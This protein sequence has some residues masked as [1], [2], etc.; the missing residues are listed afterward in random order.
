MQLLC[1]Y[2]GKGYSATEL[3]NAMPD[4]VSGFPIVHAGFTLVIRP[5][6]VEYMIAGALLSVDDSGAGWPASALPHGPLIEDEVEIDLRHRLLKVI[7][8]EFF[9]LTPAYSTLSVHIARFADGHILLA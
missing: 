4:V 3:R 9:D 2:V 1:Q 5:E 6:N 8:H 7:P